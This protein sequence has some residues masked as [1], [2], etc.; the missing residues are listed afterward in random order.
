MD[1]AHIIPP[2]TPS[3]WLDMDALDHNI[4]LVN[5]KT[6]AVKLRLATKSIR[7]LDVLRYIQNKSPHFVGLMSYA[8]DGHVTLERRL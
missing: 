5:Q 4:K 8:A 7:S 3:A 2:K 6:Q 1:F